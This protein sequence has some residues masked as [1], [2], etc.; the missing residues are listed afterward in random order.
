[1]S[2]FYQHHLE[3]GTPFVSTVTTTADGHLGAGMNVFGNKGIVT[4]TITGAAT[5][6]TSIKKDGWADPCNIEVA[7]AGEYTVTVS[8]AHGTVEDVWVFV[9]GPGIPTN[10][11]IG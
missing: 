7:P 4:L 1:M 3:A 8:T 6:S 2:E 11:P 5:C 9:V 10:D